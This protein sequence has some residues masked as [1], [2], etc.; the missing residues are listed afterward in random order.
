MCLIDEPEYA[1]PGARYKRWPS[2]VIKLKKK[3][4]K[5]KT[6]AFREATRVSQWI[7]IP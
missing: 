2:A 3:I 5:L 1:L 6:Y 4:K 7:S